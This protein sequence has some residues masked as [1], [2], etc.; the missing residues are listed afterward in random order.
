MFMSKQLKEKAL[1]LVD[2]SNFYFKLRELKILNTL[3]FDYK[4]FSTHLSAGYK[5]ID[6]RYY[7][8][9]VQV[10]HDPRSIKMLTKQ[11]KLFSLLQTA[12]WHYDLGYLL[13]SGGVYHEKGVD[14]K[15]ATDI[16]TTA[17]EK[18]AQKI[19]LVSSDTDLIPAIKRAINRGVVVEYVGF[20]HK[21]STA[22]MINCSKHRLLT[23]SEIGAFM[24]SNHKPN[25]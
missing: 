3:D 11:Q 16:L 20:A 5:L 4:A 21:P 25:P 23:D 13:K 2:G 8:G 7:V 22:M 18:L 24:R 12:D 14:V 1:I 6:S 15:I 9:K 10:T 17:Y 19:I